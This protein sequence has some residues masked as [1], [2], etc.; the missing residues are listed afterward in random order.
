[1]GT[2]GS[3][4]P[5]RRRPAR[6]QVRLASRSRR[7]WRCRAPLRP[8]AGGDATAGVPSSVRVAVAGDDGA[9]DGAGGWRI[10][11][12]PSLFAL[13]GFYLLTTVAIKGI[14]TFGPR[15]LSTAYEL[16]TSLSNLALTLFFVGTA[17]GILAGGHLADTHAEWRIIVGAF[18]VAVVGLAMLATSVLVGGIPVVA[19][20]TVVGFAVGTTLPSRDSLVSTVSPGNAGSSFGLVFT[21]LALGGLISP[22]V[23]G[24]VADATTSASRSSRSRAATSPPPPSSSRPS[25]GDAESE[26]SRRRGPT[27]KNR[28][29]PELR[30]KLTSFLPVQSTYDAACSAAIFPYTAAFISPVPPG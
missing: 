27:E 1:V 21:G 22:A 7:L 16:P 8:L 28:S 11:L 15:F 29:S 20:L 18:A 25:P 13:F 4:S 2:Q 3:R 10:L 9:S 5:R 23:L 6:R 30:A 12:T 19:L 14:Q 17:V 26:E 24:A